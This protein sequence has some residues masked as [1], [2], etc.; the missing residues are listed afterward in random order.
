M[1]GVSRSEYG[2]EDEAWES[3]RVARRLWGSSGGDLYDD[4][5]TFRVSYPHFDSV[6]GRGP[7]V[8]HLPEVLGADVFLVKI[9]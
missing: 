7:S 8:P 5:F 9:V 2:G 1:C 6:F 4:E 3:L